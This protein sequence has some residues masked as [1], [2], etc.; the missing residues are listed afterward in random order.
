MG[1]SHV[2][3]WCSP[4]VNAFRGMHESASANCLSHITFRV[5]IILPSFTTWAITSNNQSWLLKWRVMYALQRTPYKVHVFLNSSAHT[6]V[7]N[8]QLCLP[9]VPVS[10]HQQFWTTWMVEDHFSNYILLGVT[11]K[12]ASHCGTQRYIPQMY[13]TDSEYVLVR[14]S[15]QLPLVAEE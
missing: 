14:S 10:Y 11:R 3:Q 13:N 4:S 9:L 5:A 6:F 12:T 1:G 15:P 8:L 7:R 2:V